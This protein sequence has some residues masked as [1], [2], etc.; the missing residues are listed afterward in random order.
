MKVT[1]LGTGTSTGVPVIG[2]GCPVCLSDDARDKRLRCAAYVEAGGVRL[3]L[4]AGPDL[5]QQALR[6]GL[7]HVDAVLITHHHFD[8]VAGLDD[9]RPFL[10]DGQGAMPCF[11][12][13][14]TADVL[15]A[16]YPYAFGPPSY[17]G[18]P[19]LK[20]VRVGEA[21]FGVASR[22]GHGSVQVQ[23][24]PVFHG[25]LPILGY[26]VGAFAY[27]TDVSRIP[28]ASFGLLGGL[29]VLVLSALRPHP[30]PTHLTFGAAAAIAQ[31][32]GARQTFFI[33]LSHNAAHAAVEADLPPGIGVGYD[34]LAFEV[35]G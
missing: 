31:R 14:P 30:H 12:N 22:V 17:P 16:M 24:V 21:P 18:A 26:R 3:L 28:E 6:A 4:D 23:P 2:C 32:V 13:A 1:L 34:G 10:F 5:R 19:N 25:A 7:R 29:D 35:D 33:H 27:L 11:A 15:E 8:H 20:L 9:L